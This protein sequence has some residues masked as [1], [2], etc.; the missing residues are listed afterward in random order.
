MK[1]MLPPYEIRRSRRA[2]KIRIAVKGECVELVLPI[3]V[4]ERIGLA[5]MEEKREWILKSMEHLQKRDRLLQ[6]QG[7]E[8]GDVI[9]WRGDWLPIQRTPAPLRAPPLLRLTEDCFQLSAHPE[10]DEESLRSCIADWLADQTLKRVKEVVYR[11][12]ER[13]APK[14]NSIRLGRNRRAWGSCGSTGVLRIHW[15]LIQAPPFA[16]EYVVVHEICHLI[17]PHHKSSFW[18]EVKGWMPDYSV[19]QSELKSWESGLR[20]VS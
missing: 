1:M 14:P 20:T 18:Q 8:Q 2:K 6:K 7:V 3:H 15:R 10:A 9:Q 16:F 5:F 11:Y 4:P 12:V 17:H 13:G 19:R